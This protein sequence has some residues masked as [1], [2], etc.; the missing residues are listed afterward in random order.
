[1][2]L[3]QH[4]DARRPI[5]LRYEAPRSGREQLMGFAW[6]GR[7][8][9]KARA[10]QAG[11]LD[12]YISLCPLDKGFLQRA[13]ITEDTFLELIAQGVTDE[14][15][16]SYFERHV[17]PAARNAANRWVLVDMAGHLDAQDREERRAA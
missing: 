17:A 13:G 1:M 2:Q 5:D 9:D 12:D 7:A 11:T 15:L 6:L 4:R 16:A 14:E 3:T 8:A 10:K